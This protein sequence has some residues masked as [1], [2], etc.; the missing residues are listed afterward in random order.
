MQV[1][2]LALASNLQNIYEA[3]S[4]SRWSHYTYLVLEDS[5][6]KPLALSERFEQEL[7]R[8]EV[9]L[10]KMRK[11]GDGHKFEEAIEPDYHIA[12]PKD[13]DGLLKEF[14][15]GDRIGLRKFKKEIGK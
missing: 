11:N 7:I 4:H 5:E 13:S 12:L 14:F 1:S 2:R 10:V 6:L 9:G 15:E 3:A 8:F